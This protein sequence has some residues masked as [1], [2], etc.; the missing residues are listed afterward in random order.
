MIRVPST[1]CQ[2]AFIAITV[3]VSVFSTSPKVLSGAA[4]EANR[5]GVVC[6][7]G[8]N[9]INELC[10]AVP[11]KVCTSNA[12]RCNFMA[13]PLTRLCSPKGSSTSACNSN[14]NCLDNNDDTLSPD[15]GL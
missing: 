6:D 9:R 12:L 1:F 3:A 8:P 4:L 2:M 10:M 15:C 7:A 5:G 13:M 11:G 14:A